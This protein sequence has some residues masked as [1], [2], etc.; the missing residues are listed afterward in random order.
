MAYY[1]AGTVSV[2][3][4]STAVTGV[5]T[6]FSAN[7]K[8][9]DLFIANGLVATVATVN[10]NTSLTLV[11]GWAGS[12]ISASANYVVIHTGSEWSSAVTASE[13]I[14]ALIAS[15]EGDIADLQTGQNAGTLVFS[16]R[17]D[18]Y[19][20][21]GYDANSK[22]EVHAD[23]TSAYNGVYKKNGVSGAGS[24]TK[25][26]D[27][28]ITLKASTADLATET[29]ARQ[30][31][32]AT[33]TALVSAETSAR[34]TALGL[35]A[36]ATALT[37][38]TTARTT[39]DATNATAI[40]A[41]VT[42][43]TAAI[44]LKSDITALTAETTARTSG[45]T[46]NATAIATEATTRAAAVTALQAM[47]VELFQMARSHGIA[48]PGDA[49]LLFTESLAGGDPTLLDPL[50]TD[51]VVNDTDGAVVR[52]T[53]ETVIAERQ[54]RAME[55]GRRYRG[56]AVLRRR[57]NNPDPA[58]DDVRVAVAWYGQGKGALSAPNHETT[59]YTYPALLVS[60]GRQE[61]TF[62]VARQ[63]GDDVD[64]VA[65]TSARYARLFIQTA[66]TTHELDVEVLDWDDITDLDEWAL[67][68]GPL[69]TRVDALEMTV[70]ALGDTVGA[71]QPLDA[72]LTA[73]AGVTVAAN[74]VVY[75]TGP[76]TFAVTAF[77][78]LGRTLAG[79][80]DAA[81]GR[82]ALGVVPGTDVQPF[83]VDL[84]AIAA[85]TSVADRIA[86]ATGSG[87]WALA[88]LTSTARSLLDDTST[89]AM[90]TTLGLTLGTNVQ[91]YDATLAAL[92]ALTVAA[93]QVIYSTG[94]DTFAVTGLTAFGRSLIDDASA[95]AGLTTL[96]VS[97]FVQTILDDGDA[98]AVRTTLGLAALALKA[99]IATADVDADAVTNAKLANVP[100]ATVK[101]RVTAATG[102]PE[103][104]S[105]SQL[106]TL[107]ALAI[108]D[109]TGLQAALDA[110]LAANAVSAYGLTL[111]DD[112]DATTARGTLGLGSLATLSAV[113][114][115]HVTNA[116]L[117]DVATATIKGRATAGT[118]D[119]EDL[120]LS[121]VRTLLALAISDVSGLTAALAAKL[122]AVPND[123]VTN[124]RLADMAT[125]RIK[126][127]TTA[128]SG[129]PEDLTAADVKAL[130]ALA[131][132]D[133][134]GLQAALDAKL[135][136]SAASAYGLTLLDDANA[137][138][139]RTTLGLGSLSTASSL[140]FTALSDVPSAY[141]GQGGKVLA[142]KA[143]VSGVEFID[144][145]SGG[146]GGVTDPELLAIAGLTSAANKVPYFTGSGTAALA[147][148]SAFGRTLAALADAAA[149]RTALE[150]D[151][152][153][154]RL[155]QQPAR[156]GWMLNR[157]MR[158]WQRGTS[159]SAGTGTRYLADMWASQQTAGTTIAVSREA[160]TVG[161]TD[162]PT[163]SPFFARYI[164]VSA[165]AAGSYARIRQPILGV[166]KHAGRT[167]TFTIYA[168]ANATKSIALE[169]FQNFGTGGS[170]SAAVTGIGVTK[171]TIGTTWAA[172]TF[173]VAVPSITG[174][175]LGTDGNDTLEICIWLEAGSDYNARTGS[176]GNQSGTFDIGLV[177]DDP[178]SKSLPF[179]PYDDL[180]DLQAFCAKTYGVAVNPG[181]VT[182][183]GHL[184]A[185][186]TV[187]G[188]GS[189]A[190]IS[191]GVS[192][193]FPR[194]MA[195]IP[196]V[197]LYSSNDGASG[198][199]YNG[200]NVAAE[201]LN[202]STTGTI[203]RP[204]SAHSVVAGTRFWYQ[205]MA[206]VNL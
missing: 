73:F 23:G 72:T 164:I 79:L 109:I 16:T 31:G 145:P 194:P 42:A 76:D 153:Y 60:G 48:R 151:D 38:E 45:D 59:V 67:D 58:T 201:T 11:M 139:A 168:K 197:T 20:A 64:V 15:V 46:T 36:D 80:A 18:L 56:R 44:A 158:H 143:D 90:R 69:D 29:T 94:A 41:E 133:V 157:D 88:T 123:H 136:A 200:A 177:Y 191:A 96:G 125:A 74:Q 91:A 156:R 66:G 184:P 54:M 182:D 130:L 27:L 39:G 192:W 113:A 185:V 82:T 7:V 122:E 141:T 135:A 138:A 17:A 148:I 108:A 167:V 134:T 116:R 50:D 70:G 9:G 174:K 34:T 5:G 183:S 102:D 126:G 205:A 111:V 166:R 10:S 87:T 52:L 37:T 150:L 128:G 61:V 154:I 105:V 147:D 93:D 98:A 62:L 198:N 114:N 1:R 171:V 13:A 140:A 132:A 63:A 127:R 121:Q 22:A 203:L 175:T 99:T 21:L 103:D 77:T 104:L 115:D 92:A 176:L 161:Q 55:V 30:A 129:D 172:Y 119:P 188:T 186:A 178:G 78:V 33:V 149:G 28:A 57:V 51:L 3:A 142:V 40:S 106:K 26:S 160:H 49:P 2:P 12:A 53:G 84:T 86:Y 190:R 189:T 95:A 180:A 89:T 181:T 107:L 162:V 43:R 152:T 187:A 101:G 75:A 144:A 110:K 35:K 170:P 193:R 159:L 195:A 165:S 32:D 137:S 14:T 19:A 71:K 25:V 47:D 196:T 206:E 155:D 204:T 83:D 163:D 97:T 199:C 85:L 202:T 68:L 100:T 146:G 179:A 4:G 117:A 124:A 120:T 81:S 173:T 8:P 131:I 112:A 6:A 65:P 118:G 24:W 169:L